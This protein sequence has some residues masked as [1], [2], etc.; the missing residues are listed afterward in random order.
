MKDDFSQVPV[1]FTL[2]QNYPNPFNPSTI[3]TYQL[4]ASREVNLKVYNLIGQ[5]MKTLVEG[6]KAVGKH[7]VIW[8][9][10]DNHGHLVSSGIYLYRL[11]I[12]TP[13][14]QAGVFVEA[15]KMTLIR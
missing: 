3:I 14:G 4:P 13:S 5:E 2:E 8:D 15:K 10:R 6:N 12:S 7:Q 1:G 11:W 9:G